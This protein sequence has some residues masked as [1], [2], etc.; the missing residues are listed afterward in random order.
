MYEQLV[1]NSQEKCF[2]RDDNDGCPFGVHFVREGGADC[3]GPRRDAFSNIAKE[4][5]SEVLPFFIR[6]SNN[7]TV[8]GK[9]ADRY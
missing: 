2:Y 1:K 9:N 4:L 5:M 6:T 8:S 3:G 7:Q